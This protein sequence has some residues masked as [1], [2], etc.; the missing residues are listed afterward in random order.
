M[1]TLIADTACIDPRAELADDVEVGPYCVIGPD[2]KIGRGTRLI[3]H[4]C[5]HGLTTL[6]EGQRRPSVRGHRRR[7][8]GRLVPRQPD[9]RRDRR[10]ER[11]PRRRDDPPR[12]RERTRRHPDRL[13][14]PA[15]GQ[16]A[17]RA[18]LRDRR[19]GHHRQQHD[20]GR[21]RSCRVV[22]DDL[23]R[24]RHPSVR[25]RSD[26]TATSGPCRGSITTCR[27]S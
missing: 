20:P 22:R 11:H 26:R 27:G 24:S 12:Q 2:V 21:S 7:A 17:R 3:A 1:A 15:D 19:P 8:P 18:R 10:P 9:P 25:D 16:R 14:Q 23:G 6:G 5:I 4:A 13:E